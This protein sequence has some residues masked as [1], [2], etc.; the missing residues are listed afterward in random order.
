MRIVWN[1]FHGRFSDSPRALYDALRDRPDLEHVWLAD[2]AHA[3]AFPSYA[4]TVD[5]DG[6]EAREVL[7]SADLVVASS[8][9]EIEWDKPAGATYLQTWHG[10]PLKRVHYDVLWAPPGRLDALDV[11]IAKWD[12]LL[13]PNAVSTPRLRRAF[14][15]DGPVLESGL[16]RNDLL[17]GPR[18]GEVR[19]RVRADLGIEPDRTVVLYAPTWRDPQG[20][21]ATQEVPLLLDVDTFGAALGEDHVLLLRAHNFV[22]GRWHVD[23]HPWLRDVSFHPDIAELYA[24]AD[25]LVTDYSSAMFDFA[26]TGRPLMFLAADLE[27]Y[28]DSIRGFYFDPIPELPGPLLRTTEELVEALRDV[29]DHREEYAKRYAAFRSTYTSLEDGHATDRVLG[30]LGL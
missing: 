4:V 23:G 29:D 6:P 3:A 20:Y 12:L 13:S 27:E 7:E 1:S 22:T 16:P 8:H 2:P 26:V 9:T 25:V 14:G 5:V 19:Q 17:A 30:Q 28:R 21:D 18:H 24:A 10:T 15:Y 11:D